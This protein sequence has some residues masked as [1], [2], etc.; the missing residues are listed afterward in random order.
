MKTAKET[1]EH[2][3]KRFSELDQNFIKISKIIEYAADHG[4]F[5]CTIEGPNE[6]LVTDEVHEELLR[7]GYLVTWDDFGDKYT[8]SW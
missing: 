7:L 6:M 3:S 8:I 1:R 2:A 5:S 4:R